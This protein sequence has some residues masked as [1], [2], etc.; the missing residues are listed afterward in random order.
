MNILYGICGF[1]NGHSARSGEVLRELVQRGHRVAVFG[2]LN[3][4]RYCAAHFPDVPV[5]EVQVPI[6]HVGRWG[7]DFL[8]SAQDPFNVLPQ[9]YPSCLL[10]MGQAL[11]YFGGKPDLVLSDYEWIAAQLAYALDVPLVTIDQQ[12]KFAG[13]QFPDIETFS[14]LEEKTRLAMF[15]PRAEARFACSFFQVNW[16]ADPRFE[17]QLIPPI[18]RQEVLALRQQALPTQA[19]Q[20]VVY[21]S[22][23][24][25]LR[26]PMAT[27]YE[28]FHQFE[29]KHFIIF[30][31][32]PQANQGNIEFRVFEGAAF[33]RAL[34]QAE[35]VI[36]TG[37]HNLLSEVVAL[38]KPVY[39][40]PFDTFDQRCCAAM[41]EMCGIGKAAL[42]FSQREMDDFFARQSEYQANLQHHPGLM[43]QFD[44]LGVLMGRLE[45]LYG[46]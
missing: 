28:L 9:A 2:F 24:G 8:K 43:S 20:V 44:G 45:A 10:A 40:L 3:S 13:F 7:V 4:Q 31:R 26:Q 36:T 19:G 29:E 33:L 11:E 39:T 25:D 6:L 42:T 37:G 18:L 16:P 38:R 17:A 32:Q 12:S 21:F 35:A 41:V 27:I 46:V 1:G 14:R 30:T 5:F 22:P 23:H 34:A 15:F